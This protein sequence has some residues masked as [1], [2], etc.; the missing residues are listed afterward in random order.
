MRGVTIR[1]GSRSNRFVN[2]QAPRSGSQRPTSAGMDAQ[3][4]D[5][6]LDVEHNCRVGYGES[7]GYSIL[8]PYSTCPMIK[9]NSLSTHSLKHWWMNRHRKHREKEFANDAT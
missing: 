4:V 7:E 2:R 8:Q 6:A 1:N 3:A 9:T 5:V